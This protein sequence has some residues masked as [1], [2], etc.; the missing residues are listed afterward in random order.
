LNAPIKLPER[1]LKPPGRIYALIWLV[2]GGVVSLMIFAL[3]LQRPQLWTKSSTQLLLSTSIL[4]SIA[5]TSLFVGGRTTTLYLDRIEHSLMPGWNWSWWISDIQDIEANHG[6]ELPITTLEI[7]FRP[8]LQ[9][10]NIRI[11]MGV[12]DPGDFWQRACT[13]IK[14]KLQKSSDSALK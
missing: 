7:V 1:I 14:S 6:G 12:Y 3:A 10:R 9:R 11:N 4:A 8:E 13:S 5:V 2:S